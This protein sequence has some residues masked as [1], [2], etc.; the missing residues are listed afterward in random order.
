M[1]TPFQ[2]GHYIWL[3][4]NLLLLWRESNCFTIIYLLLRPTTYIIDILIIYRISF[5]NSPCNFHNLYFCIFVL[6]ELLFHPN[7]MPKWVNTSMS[8]YVN[9][10][11]GRIQCEVLTTILSYFL[12]RV[13]STTIKNLRWQLGGEITLVTFRKFVTSLSKNLKKKLLDQ[14]T[15]RIQCEVLTT[16]LSSF[17]SKGYQSFHLRFLIVVLGTF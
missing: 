11:T 17:F 10:Y 4:T 15:G 14:Y 8:S 1:N 2:V 9:Q 7:S 3:V 6:G 16:I 13:S 12:L 5:L